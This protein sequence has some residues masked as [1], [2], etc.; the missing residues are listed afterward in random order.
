M[1]QSLASMMRYITSRREENRLID[2]I[3]HTEHYLSLC[4]IPYGDTFQYSI[5]IPPE[6]YNLSIPKLTIQ[7][8]VEN[9]VSH[10]F[11][12]SD[13]HLLSLSMEAFEATGDGV[14][15]SLTMDANSPRTK[16]RNSTNLSRDVKRRVARPWTPLR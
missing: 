15:W 3:M 12:S 4:Q 10:G 5:M 7:P 1:C 2:E 9:A 13:H 16:L 14:W 6:M 8:I 11:E